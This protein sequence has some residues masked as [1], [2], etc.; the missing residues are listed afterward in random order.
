MRTPPGGPAARA[1]STV[2]ASSRTPSWPTTPMLALMTFA[3]SFL[4]PGRD[5]FFARPE[6]V[7]LYKLLYFREGGSDR[8]LRDIAGMLAVSGSE[9]DMEYLA[10]WARRLAVSDLWE[11]TRDRAS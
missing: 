2:S 8:H 7:I 5:A 9:L 6:D 11:A 1:R 10:D 3:V 4:V